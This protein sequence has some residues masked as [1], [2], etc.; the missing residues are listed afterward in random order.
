MTVAMFVLAGLATAPG[1]GNYAPV[2]T[3][4]LVEAKVQP[5]LRREYE[6]GQP[7]RLLMEFHCDELTNSIESANV[8]GAGSKM[9]WPELPRVAG[10]QNNQP[11][12]RAG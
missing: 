9:S 1:Q 5:L 10:R 3:K 4:D 6:G 2:T 12:H 11:A 8:T 7:G